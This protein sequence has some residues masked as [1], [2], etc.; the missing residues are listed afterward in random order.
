MK[1]FKTKLIYI[2]LLNNLFLNAFC[3]NV[4]TKCCNK[5]YIYCLLDDNAYESKGK[6]SNES[7]MYVCK[8]LYILGDTFNQLE[9]EKLIKKISSKVA[10]IVFNSGNNFKIQ[11]IAYDNSKKLGYSIL[12]LNLHCNNLFLNKCKFESIKKFK[13]KGKFNIDK[14]YKIVKLYLNDF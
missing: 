9:T 13:G 1:N 12:D 3:Q 6:G 4:E 14:D 5:L 8:H 2:F 7:K 10:R 11:K